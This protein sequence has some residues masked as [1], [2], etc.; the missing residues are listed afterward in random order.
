MAKID[1]LFLFAL[2]CAP[3]WACSCA[4]YPSP[5]EAWLDSPLVFAGIVEKAVPKRSGEWV[6]AREQSAWVRVTEPFKGV[7]RDQ[8]L[9]LWGE[10]SSCF[11]GFDKGSSLLFYLHP[12]GK[13]GK[14]MTPACHRTGDLRSAAHD[15]KFLRGLPA[16]A[17]GN[18][19]SGSVEFWEDSPV[20]EL[21]LNHVFQGVRVHAVGSPGSYESETDA[22]GVYEFRDLPPGTYTI[23]IDYPK[24]TALLFPVAIGRD[25]PSRRLNRKPG[26]DMQL[27]VTDSSGNGYD[28]V[29]AADTR[30]SGHVLDPDGRP[31]KGVCLELEVLRHKGPDDSEISKCTERDGS[32]VLEK[33]PAGRYRLAVN[34]GGEMSAASPFSKFYYPGTSDTDKAA[35]LTVAAGQHLDGID[36]RVS[37]L[38]RRIELRG[39]LIFSDGVPLPRQSF[40]F[41]KDGGGYRESG[42]TDA[43]GN[44]VLPILAGRPGKLIGSFSLWRDLQDACPQFGAKFN[45][46]GYG[47]TL[48]STPTAISGTSDL[49]GIEIV[50]PFPSCA[51]WLKR[52]AERK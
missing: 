36:I 50:F 24:G 46:N 18:R 16:S 10:I 38:A 40:E 49:S 44:F 37:K 48:D 27:V 39:R 1:R 20:K 31:M 30:V 3:A 7:A 47:A 23:S 41:R 8:V 28:F 25:N 45:P 52:E 34:R 42:Y 4:S 26:S 43:E 35:I 21:P 17:H 15:L 33:M 5:K 29:L 22:Q 51:A 13:P 9:E 12:S 32:Y 19:V 6:R 11:G 2:T 14:W